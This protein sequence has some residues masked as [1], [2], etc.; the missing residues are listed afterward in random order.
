MKIVPSAINRQS[1]LHLSCP[2]GAS[3]GFTALIDSDMGNS[4]AVT[5]QSR[6]VTNYWMERLEFTG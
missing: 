2:I 1:G 3:L 4:Q 5:W 6:A